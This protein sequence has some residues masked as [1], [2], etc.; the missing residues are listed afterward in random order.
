MSPA[1]RREATR[2]QRARQPAVAIGEAVGA[3]LVALAGVAVGV[4]VGVALPQAATRRTAA[5]SVA[6]GARCR[7]KLM[8]LDIAM[9]PGRT[10]SAAGSGPEMSVS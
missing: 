5:I 6:A 3:A 9:E 7:R 8:T 4:A 10:P 2:W 1:V